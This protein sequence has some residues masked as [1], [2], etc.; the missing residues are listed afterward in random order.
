MVEI[1]TLNLTRVR[2]RLYATIKISQRKQFF[3]KRSTFRERGGEWTEAQESR[4]I[5]L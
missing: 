4:F 5:E 2:C 1:F 3:A